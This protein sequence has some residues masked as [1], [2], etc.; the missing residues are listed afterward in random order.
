M[1]YCGI[2]ESRYRRS[3]CIIESKNT[4][5]ILPL[6]LYRVNSKSFLGAQQQK[7]TD[8]KRLSLKRVKIRGPLSTNLAS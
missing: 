3:A 8:K 1:E 5:L 4:P 7:G 6:T 2:G